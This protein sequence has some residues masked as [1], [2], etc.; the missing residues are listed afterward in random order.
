MALSDLEVFTD[1]SYGSM[2]ETVAQQVELFNAATNGGITLRTANNVGDYKDNAKWA[3]ISGLV[4]RRD[5]YGSGAVAAVAL[6]QLLET[7]VKVAAGTPPVNIDPGMLNWIQR[8]PSEAGIV[9]GEQLAK[10]MMADMLNAAIGSYVAG[11]GAV[12]AVNY[13]GTAG[14]ASLASL[15]NTA[16]K[17][18]DASQSIESWVMHSK[19]LF[20]IYG[21]ALANS[22]SLF[23]FGTVRVMN[24][25]FGRP[26]VITDSSNLFFDNAGT[27]NYRQLG[28][29]NGGIIVEQ[30]NDFTNNI[31]T[32][33][34][35]VNILRTVQAEWSYNLGMKGLTWDKANGGASPTDAELTTAT[36]W[37]KTATSDKDLA[38]VLG[39]TL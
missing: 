38:G 10:G 11:I 28:L 21:S 39:T 25:G 31:D 24:D 13:D 20:D 5:A 29:T 19:S 8:D 15:N 36:N 33:N 34:G 7:S 32:S 4:R 17:F 26:L 35:D 12:A 9:F 30:N 14:T 22:E 2:T 16:A 6:A 18:G 1:F 3:A 23:T 37:D 27:D